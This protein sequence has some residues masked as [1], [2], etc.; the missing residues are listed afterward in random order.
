MISQSLVAVGID[1]SIVG[2]VEDSKDFS[3]VH[4]I[5]SGQNISE[6]VGKIV[7]NRTTEEVIFLLD[8]SYAAAAK[9]LKQRGYYVVVAGEAHIEGIPSGV[10]KDIDSTYELINQLGFSLSAAKISQ[11]EGPIGIFE[12]ASLLEEVG[13]PKNFEEEK[14]LAKIQAIKN[15]ASLSQERKDDTLIQASS[16]P[17][18]EDFDDIASQKQEQE[19]EAGL[20]DFETDGILDAIN[21]LDDLYLNED[22]INHDEH[23]HEI[24]NNLLNGLANLDTSIEEPSEADLIVEQG[25]SQEVD[26][27]SLFADF[28]SFPTFEEPKTDQ[29]PSTPAPAP[30]IKL[31]QAE[32]ELEQEHRR[33]DRSE[34]ANSTAFAPSKSDNP[35]TDF[36]DLDSI[37]LQDTNDR[38]SALASQYN[39][40]TSPNIDRPKRKKSVNKKANII[41]MFIAKGGTGKT[42]VSYSLAARLASVLAK[43]G[44]KRVAFLD[45]NRGNA[46]VAGYIGLDLT[47]VSTLSA[48]ASEPFITED[49]LARI[50]YKDPQYNLDVIF[51]PSEADDQSAKLVRV[52]LYR[53]VTSVLA[54]K[55][56]YIFIDT[57]AAPGITGPEDEMDA[58]L[59]T[60]FILND[61]DLLVGVITP[62]QPLINRTIKLFQVLTQPKYQGIGHGLERAKIGVLLNRY[63]YTPG[64]GA[65]SEEDIRSQLSS[66]LWWGRIPEIDEWQN[67]I[68]LGN[69]QVSNPN[70]VRYIDPILAR[71]TREPFFTDD[72]VAVKEDKGQ[73]F[74]KL[75]SR[76]KK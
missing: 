65:L 47:R 42:S 55:Y 46:D 34:P 24:D 69:S 49:V 12:L 50:I 56:D 21:S 35:W 15:I 74:G 28:M 70:V 8:A 33:E 76:K 73:L 61:A 62:S 36:A 18:I 17:S 25:E 48:I 54:E 3:S 71:L 64:K 27:N 2:A 19:Q 6:E 16:T 45:A 75:F 39:I 31:G 5:E 13:P 51:S 52:D 30:E 37:N 66:W 23:E 68:N 20:D 58:R 60:E 11:D 14:D 72:E 1:R 44:N 7:T 10:V 57:P 29:A 63:K 43:N 32:Q 38:L 9:V 40:S 59:F 53:E 4:L 41:A 26:F 22:T 67:Y